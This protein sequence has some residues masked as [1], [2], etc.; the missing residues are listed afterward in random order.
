MPTKGIDATCPHCG[1][2][3]RVCTREPVAGKPG[4]TYKA[5]SCP[6]CG[7][8]DRT[9]SRIAHPIRCK[10]PYCRDELML[11]ELTSYNGRCSAHAYAASQ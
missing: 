10:E 8:T 11:A 6:K 7:R 3:G 9:R 2:Y 5:A 4:A 1:R